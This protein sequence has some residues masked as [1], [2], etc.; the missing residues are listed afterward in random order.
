MKLLAFLLL[1]LSPLTAQEPRFFQWTNGLAAAELN[2]RMAVIAGVQTV[3]SAETR[4]TAVRAKI[5]ELIGGLPQSTA[6]LNARITGTLDMGAYSIQKILFESMPGLIVSSLLYLPKTSGPHPAVVFQIGHFDGGKSYDQTI[7]GNLAI[8]GFVV[9]AFD[10]I[11]EGERVQ[12]YDPATG[13][14]VAGVAVYQHILAGAQSILMG[15]NFARYEIFDAQRAIDYLVSRPEVDATRIGMTGCSGG[16]TLATYVTALDP[17]IKASAPACYIQSFVDGYPTNSIGDSEQSFAGFLSSLLDEADYIELFSPQPFLILTTTLDPIPSGTQRVYDE[18]S[19]WYSLYGAANRLQWVVGPGGHGTPLEVRQAIYGWMIQWLNNNVGDSTE[20]TVTTLPNSQLL[21]SS[22]GQVGG[23][24]IYQVIRATPRTQGSRSDLTVLLNQLVAHSP[25]TPPVTVNSQTDNGSYLTQSISFTTEANLTLDAS[26]LIPKTPGLKP[27]VILVEST[28]LGSP[29]AA[30]LAASGIVVLDLLPRGLPSGIDPTLYAGDFQTNTRAFMIG[31]FLPALRAYDILQ[32]VEILAARGDVDPARISGAASG[33]P[34]FWLLLAAASD[35]RLS[36]IQLDHTPYSF[37]AALDQPVHYDLHDAAITGFSL[38]FDIP[39]LLNAVSPRT[40]VWTNPADW[41]RNVAP[42]ISSLG[43]ASTHAGSFMQG[44]LSATYKVTVSNAGTAMMT[45]GTVTVTEALPAGLTLLSMAGAGWNCVG[46]ACIRNDSISAGTSYPPITVTV[47][48]AANASTLLLN[49]VAISG[50]G[51]AAA[52]AQDSTIVIAN[53]PVLAISRNKLNFSFNGTTVT[54][55][56]AITVSFTG[57]AAGTW[58]ASSNQSNINVTPSSGQGSGVFQVAVTAGSGGI[59]TVASPGAVNSPL[60]IQ[61]NLS[62]ASS[63]APFGSFDTPL[64]NTSRISGAIPVTGWALDNIEIA[65]VDV[66]REPVSSEPPGL[67]Y[68]G[69]A[70]F[71]SGARPD[72]EGLYPN[73][74]LNY[75]AGWGY[76]MLTNSLPAL[77]NGVYRLHAIAHNQAGA[78]TDLGTRTI[79][80]DNAHANKPFGTID[81]PGQGGTASGN[82]YLNFGWALTQNPFVI[83][84]DGST[85]TVFVDGQ[86]QGH[87]VYNQ[88]RA[89]IAN[90]FPGL[91]NSSG[92][93]GFFYLDTTAL[94]NGVHTISWTVYDNAG[95]GDGVGSRFFNV[96]NNASANAA[97]PSQNLYADTSIPDKVVIQ[98]LD[99]IEL[100]IGAKEGYLAVGDERRALPIGSSIRDGVFYWQ[101][102]AGFLGDYYLILLRPDGSEHRLRVRIH[103][104]SYEEIESIR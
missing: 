32:G 61:V 28:A 92:P 102:T 68:I 82:A 34:G 91:A 69:D 70:V 27:G 3:A 89:D 52:G 31:K 47:R 14:G 29:A 44:Q 83:P 63:G 54:S 46:N 48:V 75:R 20:Q 72:V 30:Q 87:P 67:I 43:I 88:F 78:A 12:D 103:P 2:Q 4:K 49:Q 16:G 79:A 22:T 74:P 7:P 65:K 35:S 41:L 99:R 26:L 10:P 17:R 50:G 8:K 25:Q 24:Q 37:Q 71:V 86:P 21:A 66:W 38:R 6:P 98:E 64:D 80:C 93:V 5:L 94:S 36:S 77:G 97:A 85:I 76:L 100:R 15:Q 13:V 90:Q 84:K 81:T 1:G 60:Q 39:D 33:V 18:A 40:V 58:T 45:T 104:K 42:Q 11:G 56:Q 55:P 9:I 96:F 23:L 95:R 101:T 19:K 62:P 57:G 51:S 73:A 53:A 59:V